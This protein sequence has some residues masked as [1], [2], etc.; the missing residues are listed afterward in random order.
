MPPVVSRELRKILLLALLSLIPGIL[1]DQVA[2]CLL[3]VSLAYSAYLL[4]KTYLL[5]RWLLGEQGTQV[6][7]ASGL[8][9]DV[10]NLIYRMRKRDRERKRRLAS[11]LMRFR[12]AI[13]ALP[14]AVI[15]L[16]AYGRIEWSNEAALAAFGLRKSDVGQPLSN[17]LRDPVLQSYLSD[18]SGD[19]QI[20]FSS[21][22]DS[23]KTL[24]LRTIHYG[25]GQRLLIARDISRLH[26]LESMRRDFIANASHELRNPLTVLSGY[27]ETFAEDDIQATAPEFI[28]PLSSMQQQTKRM[29]RI[30]ED[31]LI[32]TRLESDPPQSNTELPLNISTIVANII[33]E[34]KILSGKKKHLISLEMSAAI[35]LVGNE[36]EIHSA[37]SNLVFNAVQY[38]PAK[39]KIIVKWAQDTN[40]SAYFEV[41]DT[42]IGIP[43]HHIPRITE[44]FYRV[45]VGRSRETGGTGLGLAIVK[46]VLNRHQATLEITS[47]PERGSR[48]ICRFPRERIQHHTQL[49]QDLPKDVSDESVNMQ[50]ES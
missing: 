44:R 4:R 14:D 13:S 7:D 30:V 2:L 16:D 15:A 36:I 3:L 48:F 26:Q 47:E 9:G 29:E 10:F 40:G 45:D 32:L 38:T 21:E 37:F 25:S 27:L 18:H 39:G 12:E 28:R 41:K 46:H 34:A 33:T 5:H 20:E 22:W 31:L 24:S 11:A 42:G 50:S 49:T 8:W 17:L 6:P 35:Q 1:Y 23:D 19:H 43:Q